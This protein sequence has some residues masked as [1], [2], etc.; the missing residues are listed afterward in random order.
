MCAVSQ[1]TI[2]VATSC[3][4]QP[5]LA[6]RQK[7]NSDWS[8]NVCFGTKPT[9]ASLQVVHIVQHSHIEL[10]VASSPD[11]VP[12]RLLVLTAA[13]NEC[14]RNAGVMDAA[15]ALHDSIIRKTMYRNYGHE[16][17]CL[18]SLIETSAVSLSACNVKPLKICPLLGPCHS[19]SAH[20]F[21]CSTDSLP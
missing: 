10:L 13:S 1:T 3:S 12:R 15:V 17:G 14:C 4:G 6:Q 18:I 7:L 2:L 19:Q 8:S 16:V 5:A 9:S 20:S 21:D 11:L